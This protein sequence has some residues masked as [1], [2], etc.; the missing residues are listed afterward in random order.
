MKRVGELV[1]MELMM[2]EMCRMEREVVSVE[3]TGWFGGTYVPD[4]RKDFMLERRRREDAEGER[5]II[6]S[7]RRPEVE[8]G[9]EGLEGIEGVFGLRCEARG[10]FVGATVGL[11]PSFWPGRLAARERWRKVSAVFRT[12]EK[13]WRVSVYSYYRG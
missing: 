3:W 12:W 13:S 10:W 9:A 5:R 7:R 1:L 2:R 8:E 6:G 4:E 11:A